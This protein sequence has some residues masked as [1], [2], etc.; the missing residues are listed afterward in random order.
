MQHF[1]ERKHLINWIMRNCIR[2]SVVR[3]MDEGTVEHLGTFTNLGPGMKNPGWIIRAISETG[4]VWIVEIVARPFING[5][6][7][8]IRPN[9]EVPVPWVPWER[10]AGGAGHPDF[11]GNPLY[12]GDNPV[13]Y[14][15]LKDERRAEIAKEDHVSPSAK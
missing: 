9:R 11:P 6:G 14:R 13:E 2:K 12:S 3:A 8:Y 10:W 15:R 5:Y 7:V 4:K 1:T